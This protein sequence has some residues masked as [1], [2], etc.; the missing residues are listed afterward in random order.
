MK[1]WCSLV[2]C[3]IALGQEID[4]AAGARLYRLHCAEC[5]GRDGSGGLGPDLTRG[6]YRRGST[7]QALFQTIV[8]GIAGTPMAATALSDRQIRQIVSHL[9]L[10]AGAVRVTVPGNA[11]AG[12]KLFQ[13][14]GGCVKCHLIQGAGGRLGPDLTHVGSLRSPAHLR[15]SILRPN[16]ES[17]P[18]LLDG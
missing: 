4:P 3:V 1:V 11:A 12:Q 2:V 17:E 18:W 8:N 13:G 9:R 5:H 7:D 15:A 14:K 6:V 10:L 16:E